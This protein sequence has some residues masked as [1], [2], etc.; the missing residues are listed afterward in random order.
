M[1]LS[2]RPMSAPSGP[3]IASAHMPAG[4]RNVASATYGAIEEIAPKA[5]V[6]ADPN[7]NFQG[8]TQWGQPSQPELPKPPSNPTSNFDTNSTTFLH[9]LTQ[10]QR[11]TS[12]GE[13]GNEKQQPGYHMVV[14]KVAKTYEGVAHV[15]SNPPHHLGSKYSATL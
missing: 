3:N 1:A 12:P 4:G 6:Y 14:D 10:H 5:E 13:L 15:I 8:F 7:Y 9:L 11:D 2:A